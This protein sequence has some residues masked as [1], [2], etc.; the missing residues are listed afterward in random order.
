MMDLRVFKGDNINDDTTFIPEEESTFDTSLYQ[1]PTNKFLH[2]PYYSYHDSYKP[3]VI[4]RLETMRFFCTSEPKYNQYKSYYCL[5]LLERG[6]PDNLLTLWF[7]LDIRRSDLINNLITKQLNPTIPNDN[8]KLIFKMTRCDRNND[9]F[10]NRILK[11]P[12]I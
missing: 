12:T 8:E 10:F 4:A 9:M 6:Y 3:T 11:L 2:L 1:K 5:Q 7:N